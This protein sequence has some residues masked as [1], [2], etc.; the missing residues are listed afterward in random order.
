VVGEASAVLGGGR[1]RAV[2]ALA[3]VALLIAYDATAMRFPDLPEWGDVLW[4]G[5]VLGVPLFGLLWLGLPLFRRGRWWLLGACLALVAVALGTG[6]ADLAS[7]ANIAKLG[8]AGAAGCLFLSFVED[9]TWLVAIALAIPI[10]DTISVWRGPTHYIV[11]KQPGYFEADSVAFPPPGERVVML[12]WDRVDGATGYVLQTQRLNG[13]QA[14]APFTLKEPGEDLVTDAHVRYRI[15]VKARAKGRTLAATRITLGAEC[16]GNLRCGL[17]QRP[18][19]GTKPL[20]VRVSA[21]T[22]AERLGLTDVLFFVLFLAGAARFGLRPGWTWIGLV[23]AFTL[24]GA[25]GLADPF[26]IGGVPALPFLSAGFL[27]PNADRLWRSVR[28]VSRGRG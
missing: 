17:A 9:V 6:F 24:S 26:G 25:A 21:R 27:V 13:S 10:A 2:A 4:T 11:T 18:V 20:P 8:A 7:V 15:D 16:H 5:I 12:R 14:K 22:A 28:A 23:A 1:A 3:V 19:A